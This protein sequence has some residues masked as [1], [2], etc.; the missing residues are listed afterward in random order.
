MEG[1][2]HWEERQFD[3]C[4]NRIEL[5]Q[6]E[7]LSPLGAFVTKL[8]T[9]KWSEYSGSHLMS[10]WRGLIKRSESCYRGWLSCER[11]PCC[12]TSE[13]EGR[14]GTL[15]L[16][17]EY[18]QL[19]PWKISGTSSFRDDYDCFYQ[20]SVGYWKSEFSSLQYTQWGRR[21]IVVSRL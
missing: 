18:Q 1:S 9:D 8:S 4:T 13:E 16:L 21:F 12:G 5:S 3:D 10:R 19:S 2:F 14:R 6:I 15:L 20:C 7:S 11:S 17:S